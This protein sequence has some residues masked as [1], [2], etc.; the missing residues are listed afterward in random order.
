MAVDLQNLAY[1]L[2]QLVHNF[3]AVA[4]TGS[5]AAA[6][7]ADGRP[8]APRGLAWLALAGWALQAASGAGFGAVSYAWYGRFP[9][10]HGIAVA[11]LV[12][13]MVC[14]AS[15]FL[16][17]AAYLRFAHRWQERRR[18]DAWRALF[19]LAAAALSAAAFLRW[20]A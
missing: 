14:A 2:V 9:E 10:L 6:W 15:G 17:A 8:P 12:V 11:A 13:K 18:R 5:A 7:W 1:A 4:V 20:F 19:A 3:G 16:L